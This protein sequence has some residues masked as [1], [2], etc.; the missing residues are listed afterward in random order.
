MTTPSKIELVVL[1]E[2]AGERLDRVI[3]SVPEVGSRAQAA[4]LIENGAV[5]LNGETARKSERVE[6]NDLIAI[7]LAAPPAGDP[8]EPAV[9]FEIVYEDESL[10]IVDKPSGLVVHP[11]PGN[12]TGTLSQALVGLAGGGD[13]ERSGIVH[14]LDKETSGLLVV[15]R[16]DN[17]LRALQKALQAREITRRYTAL[18][19]GQA[20]S[21][22]GTIDA[23]LGRDR[24][25][26]ENISIRMDSDRTAVTHFEVVEEIG[27]RSLLHVSLETGRTHQI[28]VHMAAIGLPVCGDPTYGIS[29]DLGLERQFLHASAL[30][31]HH[32]VTNEPMS[33]GSPLPP[34]L[35]QALELARADG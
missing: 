13:P 25:N 35:A 31:F 12:R 16:N 6:E 15:A 33:F 27:A 24:R 17:V 5:A 3:S 23:P 8:S 22:S 7:E 32:P 21:S 26:P 34:D 14:R 4:K 1:G 20:E 10:L 18:V 11:A 2:Q 30:S 29:G 19:R 28:R 9:P